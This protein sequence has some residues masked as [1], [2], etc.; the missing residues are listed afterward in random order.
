MKLDCFTKI[1]FP[2][3]HIIFNSDVLTVATGLPEH[4]VHA[5]D[6]MKQLPKLNKRSPCVCFS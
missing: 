1:D 5:V 3:G 6:L 2:A 4:N